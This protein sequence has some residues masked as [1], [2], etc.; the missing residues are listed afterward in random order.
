MLNAGEPCLSTTL[1]L[2][3]LHEVR[4]A[5]KPTNPESLTLLAEPSG[6]PHHD[7]TQL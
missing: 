5:L 1:G 6:T 3:H 4:N 2:S 7:S